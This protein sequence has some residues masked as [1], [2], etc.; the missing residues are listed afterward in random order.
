MLGALELG[1]RHIDTAEMYQNETEIGRALTQSYVKREDLF[2]TTKVWSTHLRR[3]DLLT[4]CEGSLR[5]L[6]LDYVDLLLV[7]W[8]NPSVPIEE[9][10]QAMD[11]LKHSG[12]A[13]QIGVS[14]FS[15]PELQKAQQ[16]CRSHIF[17]NQV[18]YHPFH[19]Q[20]EIVQHCQDNDLV[21]T[22]YTPLAK[23]RVSRDS[24]LSEIG[25]GYGKTGAQ[26][27]LRWLVQQGHVICIPKAANAD[28]QKENTGIFDFELSQEEMQR[29]SRL[30]G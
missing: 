25:Y 26:V 24:T 7:H 6:G 15:V 21:L 29:I 27:T 17:S 22:A 4:A 14:N 12:K 11:E 28:H 8:P 16:S 5:R 3:P 1:Y 2:L 23:G 18:E 20:D 9:T 13:R 19:G 10:M 30:A